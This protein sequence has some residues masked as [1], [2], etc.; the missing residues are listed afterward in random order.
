[1]VRNTRSNGGAG[2]LAGTSGPRTPR[3]G[4]PA[5]IRGS[6]GVVEERNGVEEWWSDGKTQYSNTPLGV[7]VFPL[8]HSV[9]FIG[10]PK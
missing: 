3:R 4:V 5:A 2:R 8:H 9:G 7:R 1:M 6:D 10:V